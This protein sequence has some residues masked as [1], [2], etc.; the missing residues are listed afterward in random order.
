[1]NGLLRVS[2]AGTREQ[3]KADQGDVAS[4]DQQQ[5]KLGGAEWTPGAPWQGTG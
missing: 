5:Q 3:Q 1:M 2:F 4:V